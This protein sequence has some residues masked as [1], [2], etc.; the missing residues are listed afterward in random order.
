MSQ[1]LPPQI[2]NSDSKAKSKSFLKNLFESAGAATKIVAKQAERTKI[3]SLTLPTAYRALGKDC[4]QQKRHLDCVTEL[5]AQLGSVLAEIKKLSEAAAAQAVPQSITDKAKAA[6]KQALDVARTKQL[7]LKRDSLIANI[8]K[9]IYERHAAESGPSELVA[10]IQKA[11]SRIAELDVEIGQQS[12]VGKGSALTPKRMLVGVGVIGLLAVFV[13]MRSLMTTGS[14]GQLDKVASNEVLGMDTSPPINSDSQSSGNSSSATRSSALPNTSNYGIPPDIANQKQWPDL[15]LA[16]VPIRLAQE[17]TSGGIR[18]LQH[19][20]FSPK[21]SQLL[22]LF[23]KNRKQDVRVWNAKTGEE[24]SAKSAEC[25]YFSFPAAFSPDEASLSCIDG[26]FLRMWSLKTSPATL[27]QSV[28]LAPASAGPGNFGWNGL[29]WSTDETLVLRSRPMAGASTYQVYRRNSGRFQPFGAEQKSPGQYKGERVSFGNGFAVSPDGR[30]S[31]LAVKSE[32]GLVVQISGCDSGKEIQE[33]P[34]PQAG[35]S[36]SV[37]TLP[38]D[39]FA[40]EMTE[41]GQW[42]D[43]GSC[44]EFSP[45]GQHLLIASQ[46]ADKRERISVMKAGDWDK[47]V[48]LECDD[49]QPGRDKRNGYLNELRLCTYSADG[50]RLAGLATQTTKTSRGESIERIGVVFDLATGKRLSSI[51]LGKDFDFRGKLRTDRA[52]KEVIKFS[53]DGSAIVVAVLGEMENRPTGI[54]TPWAVGA[55]ELSNGTQ[56]LAITGTTGQRGS[57]LN[58]SPDGNILITP[59]KVT[60]FD[61]TAWDVPHFAKLSS[62]LAQGDKLWAAGTH[63]EAFK[64]YCMV[65]GDN[66]AWFV[67]ADLPRVTSR[68]IDTFAERGEVANGR[69]LVVQAQRSK[70]SIA[71]ETLKGKTLVDEFLSEEAEARRLKSQQQSDA[72]TKALADVRAKNKRL[73]VPADQLTKNKFID[74]LKSTMDIGRIDNLA[75]YALFENYS[76]QDVFGDPDSNVEWVDV[77]RLISYRCSDGSVQLTVILLEG[78]TVLQGI[79]QY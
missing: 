24:Y 35:N 58:L 57:G 49:L 52:A 39:I 70:R 18:A 61:F 41:Q 43:P 55:W 75:V 67:E 23:E 6:G 64:H 44:L 2:N 63:S 29:Q 65:L 77:Q 10:P 21:G 14:T 68:C 5:T 1:K 7:S 15:P 34:L 54:K 47:L 72:A 56:R 38:T 20:F 46:G 62:D 78:R 53:P 16:Q 76:F 42:S 31:A 4:L 50:R 17:K 79:N 28:K 40:L 36:F 45:D 3:A 60:G 25:D 71:P 51:D 27:K 22:L 30:Y 73:F 26:D 33:I 8:G 48:S 59:G 9:A 37:C 74:K 69:N 13:T 12:Q 32:K 11:I 19:V 66:M